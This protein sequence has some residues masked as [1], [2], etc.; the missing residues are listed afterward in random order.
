[1][2]DKNH[3]LKRLKRHGQNTASLGGLATRFLMGGK[4]D[5]PDALAQTLGTLKGPVMKVAQ[6]L[7]TVPDMLPLDYGEALSALQSQAPPMGWLF[8]KRRLKQE[9]GENWSDHFHA[10]DQKASAAA[11][12]GQVH[13]ATHQ[14]GAV[15][16][17][18]VQ[19]PDM[20]SVVEADLQ[21]VTVLLKLY[22]KSRGSL[23]VDAVLAEIRDRLREE[24]DYAQELGHMKTFQAIFKENPRIHV[25]RAHPEL[26]TKKLL[27]MDWLEGEKLTQF[28]SAP[29]ALRNQLAATLF[30]AWYQPL[31]HYGVLHGDPHLGNYTATKEGHLNLFDFGC[32]RVFEPGFIEGILVLYQALREENPKKTFEAYEIWGFEHLTEEVVEVLNLW[33]R[34][35][36]APLLEDKVRYIHPDLNI[37][38]GQTLA[39]TIME[40]LKGLGGIEPPRAFVFM[41]RAAVGLGSV[42]MR[43]KA[44][45]NWHQLFEELIHD[46]T[47]DR[48]LKRQ[49]SVVSDHQF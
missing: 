41:D 47:K 18:K 37:Q 16:G 40:K 1:M 4:E 33:A 29:Q 28:E 38:E 11:S 17:V 48:L 10:F 39:R 15:L 12:L 34:Y 35:L 19:Y 42:F 27:T 36:Y 31:Y 23:K 5:F 6:I 26:S 9:L 25:P 43:L 49:Q 7:S 8:V 24:L 22:E 32:V 46:F 21:Q 3:F 13:K 44:Q 2:E 14:D 45:L 20:A 30:Q